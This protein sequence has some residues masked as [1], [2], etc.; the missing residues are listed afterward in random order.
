MKI[1]EIKQL[2]SGHDKMHNWSH[3]LRIKRKVKL[4]RKDY[5]K[6]DEG[7][8]K[9]LILFHGLKDYV[10]KNQKKF[11]KEYVKSLM[12]HYKNPKKIEEKLVHDANLLEN[13]GRFGVKKALFVGKSMRENKEKTYSFLR[14]YIDKAKFYTKKG[15]EIGNKEVKIMKEIIK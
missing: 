14:Q 10:R 1:K 8:L 9:F 15:K 5:K 6:I 4:L 12:R 3:I 13:V 2:Y 7:L 11:D